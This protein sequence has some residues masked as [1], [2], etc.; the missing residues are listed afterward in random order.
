MHSNDGLCNETS[1]LA[2]DPISV[3]EDM[4]LEAIRG[5]RARS[6]GLQCVDLSRTM[7]EKP[8]LI[9]DQSRTHIEGGEPAHRATHS[10]WLE[11]PERLGRS[12]APINPEVISQSARAM[13]AA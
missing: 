5:T 7:I 2:L 8:S 6:Y 4:R 3:E 9:P 13:P 10:I 11:I 1:N 12:P